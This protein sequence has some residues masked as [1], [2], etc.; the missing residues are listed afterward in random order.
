ME[1]IGK[2]LKSETVVDRLAFDRGQFK[3]S[4][5]FTRLNTTFDGELE[6][7]LNEINGAIWEEIS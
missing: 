4:G 7:I 1:R 5:G 6:A 2:Q 3:S